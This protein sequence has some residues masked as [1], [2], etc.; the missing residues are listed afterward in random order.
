MKKGLVRTSTAVVFVATCGHAAFGQTEGRAPAGAVFGGTG[1]GQTGS[2][3]KVDIAE[4]YDQDLQAGPDGT[5]ASTFHGGG[6]YSMLTPQMD[7]QTSGRVQLHITAI[8]AA[9]YYGEL[10]EVIATN[11]S[12][13]VSLLAQLTPRTSISLNPSVAYSPALFG[14]VFAN[15]GTVTTAA[16]TALPGSN[17]LLNTN[18]SYVYSGGAEI[19]HQ[20]TDRAA[21]VFD[22]GLRATTFTRKEPGYLDVKSDDIGGRFTYST[23]RNVKLRLG[24]TYSDGQ[25]AGFPRSVQHN[26]DVGMDYSRPLSR[27]RKTAF[28]FRIGPTVGKNTAVPNGSQ[29]LRPQYQMVVDAMVNH[30]LGRTWALQGTYRRGVG[31]YQGFQSPAFTGAYGGSVTGFLTRRTDLNISAAYSSVESILSGEPSRLTT[32]TAEA[33]YRFAISRHWA[34]Y[35]E[36]SRYEYRFDQAIQLPSQVP[37]ALT[38]NSVRTGLTMW[39]PVRR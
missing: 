1:S 13:A 33:R 35:V 34:A 17:D 7:F 15:F 6:L 26:L 9:R 11:H 10:H 25:Y 39:I 29:E 38:R 20:L 5:A 28:T 37:L 27:T 23:N 12:A 14:G 3:L 16:S 24:Y 2:S 36:G 32:Y 4:A 30:Q 8:S 18:R 19:S 31:Y 22:A 21:V